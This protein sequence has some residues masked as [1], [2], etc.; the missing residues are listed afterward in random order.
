MSAPDPEFIIR[1]L[2][3]RVRLDARRAEWERLRRKLIAEGSR[4]EL[5]REAR[6]VL[7]GLAERL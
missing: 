2:I 7:L 5:P 3:D 6:D 4:P 1:Q